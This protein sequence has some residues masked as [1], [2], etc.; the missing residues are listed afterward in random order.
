MCPTPS[1]QTQTRAYVDHNGDLH[2]PDYRD[3]PVLRPSSRCTQPTKRRTSASSAA[4]SRSHDRYPMS[5]QP[6]RPNWE[7]DWG[8]EVADSD[9]EDDMDEVESQS[10]FSPFASHHGSPRRNHSALGRPTYNSYYYYADAPQTAS[11]LGSYED[12]SP[13][14]L[15]LHESPF[16]DDDDGEVVEESRKTACLIRK[17]SKQKKSMEA[18]TEKEVDEPSPMLRSLDE[19]CFEDDHASTYVSLTFHSYPTRC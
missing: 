2:D 19:E 11:P 16:G 4:R 5:M 7:R 12:E 10:H 18:E 3:F 1:P 6:P 13:N 17:V 14:A 15:Q 9:D 8:T